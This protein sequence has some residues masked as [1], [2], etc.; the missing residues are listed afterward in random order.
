MNLS[1][2]KYRIYRL[3]RVE[4]TDIKL[5]DELY[6]EFELNY[7][8]LLT[9][10]KM[11]DWEYYVLKD[12][13]TTVTAGFRRK[14]MIGIERYFVRFHM[15]DRKFFD[16]VVVDNGGN[17]CIF[18]NGYQHDAIASLSIASKVIAGVNRYVS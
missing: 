4:A 7:I 10:A 12:V 8:G 15:D 2:E 18:N 17:K 1:K 16:S 5:L 9:L 11:T 6:N 3:G 14:S 13:G